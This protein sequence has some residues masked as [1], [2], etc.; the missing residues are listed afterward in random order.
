MAMYVQTDVRQNINNPFC[1]VSIQ[2]KWTMTEVVR[3]KEKTNCD[4]RVLV[5][6]VGY[7]APELFRRI[8]SKSEVVACNSNASICI[9]IRQ[10]L[11][12][13]DLK[14]QIVPEIILINYTDL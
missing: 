12:A 10:I 7:H 6:D 8:F 3:R 2:L 9:Q 14:I 4:S 5:P 13:N 11:N 1:L